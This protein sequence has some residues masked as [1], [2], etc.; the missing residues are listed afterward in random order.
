MPFYSFCSGLDPFHGMVDSVVSPALLLLRAISPSK[1]GP[2]G[3]WLSSGWL[4]FIIFAVVDILTGILLSQNSSIILQV[5]SMQLILLVP[6]LQC[7]LA[8]YSLTHTYIYI[9]VGRG[10]NAWRKS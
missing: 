3:E 1:Y 4:S 9:D 6:I 5:L 2:N 10:T 8:C 7:Q